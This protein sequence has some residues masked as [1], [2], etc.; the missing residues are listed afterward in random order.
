[1][2][3]IPQYFE[4]LFFWTYEAELAT[5]RERQL[6][7]ARADQQLARP[8]AERQIGHRKSCL[9]LSARFVV[10]NWRSRPVA[11]SA[12]FRVRRA[13]GE[14]EVEFKFQRET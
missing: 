10:V 2:N 3:F 8:T 11:T 14:L 12:Y 9:F 4:L 6:T 13:T 7:T 1:M 5:E